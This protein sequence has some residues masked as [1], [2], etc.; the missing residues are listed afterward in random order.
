MNLKQMVARVMRALPNMAPGV[1]GEQ[2]IVDILNQGQLHLSRISAKVIVSEY[3]LSANYN[4]VPFP[5]DLLTIASVYWASASVERE[6]YPAG[7]KIPLGSEDPVTLA[8]TTTAGSTYSDSNST[9]PTRYYTKGGRIMIYPLP[10]VAGTV[11]IA[12]VPKP[13]EMEEDDDTPDMEGSE[14][15]LIAFALHRLH[16]EAGSPLFQL[17]EMEK[18]KEEYTYMQTTDQNYRT[19]FQVEARW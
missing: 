16:L 18:G 6:L 3:S 10:K 9:E 2:D 17:W 19:P 7:N 15:Y 14:N 13:T 11:S 4:I 1:V 5:D 8:I 12:Y